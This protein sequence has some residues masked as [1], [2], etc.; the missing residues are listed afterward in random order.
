MSKILITP[1]GTSPGV[2]Y[3]ALK[4]TNPDLCIIVTSEKGAEKISEIAEKSDFNLKN[5]KVIKFNNPFYGFEE[6]DEKIKNVEKYLNDAE[7]IYFNLSG[8]TSFLQY[9]IGKIKEIVNVKN[10]SF[11]AVDKR[12]IFQ[13]KENPYVIGEWIEV[14]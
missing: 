14:K 3:T 6:I 11:F 7:E 12:D 2:V 4:S 1:L 10:K 5:I 8:G 13:Q 9:V